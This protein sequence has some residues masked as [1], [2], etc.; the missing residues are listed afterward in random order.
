MQRE[1]VLSFTS[2]GLLSQLGKDFVRSAVRQ[3]GRDGGKIISNKIYG[4]AH[5]T[6]V[7]NVGEEHACHVSS[8][9]QDASKMI[10]FKCYGIMNLDGRKR[11]E[12]SGYTPK[13]NI[14]HWDGFFGVACFI[15]VFG[16]MFYCSAYSKPMMVFLVAIVLAR[17]FVKFRTKSRKLIK[18]YRQM[19][20][21]QDNRCKTGRRYAGDVLIDHEIDVELYE[22]EKKIISKRA[23]MYVC[24]AVV[25]LLA[26]SIRT[27]ASSYYHQIVDER[28]PQ[29]VIQVDTTRD[30][31]SDDKSI[32]L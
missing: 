2:M 15:F 12:A 20:Y 11:A 14:N 4:D 6:P 8:D 31:K 28:E 22:E 5:S 19:T 24:L 21:E 27:I 26:G 10:E 7:R 13:G 25:L 16:I 30:R 3:V 23:M 9:I 18:P 1:K 29:D 32:N 17:A